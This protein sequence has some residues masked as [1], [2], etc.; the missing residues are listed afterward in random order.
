MYVTSYKIIIIVVKGVIITLA[1]TKVKPEQ[2]F[3]I[4]T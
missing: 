4:F 1:Y 3:P 2:W